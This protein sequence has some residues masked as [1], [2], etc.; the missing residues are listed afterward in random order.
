M[1][2]AAAAGRGDMTR[3]SGGSRV[4]VRCG[5]KKKADVWSEASSMYFYVRIGCI[6]TGV[7]V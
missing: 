1:D 6:V 5:Q 2:G 7:S 3:V 4:D